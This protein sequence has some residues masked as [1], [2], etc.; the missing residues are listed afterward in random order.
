MKN[1]GQ[2]VKKS[3]IMGAA[4]LLAGMALAGCGGAGY[5]DGIYSAKSEADDSGAWAEVSIT[6]SGEKIAGCDFVTRQKDGS[7]KDENYGKINGEI[8]NRDYYAK[9]QLAVSAMKKYEEEFQRSGRHKDVEAV[10]G[11]TIA[12]EQ[13]SEAAGAALEA[14]KK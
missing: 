13:F 7:V 4:A 3:C 11:A 6:I 14:A 5:R 8:S 1:K 9:A 12:Y 2:A 10:S